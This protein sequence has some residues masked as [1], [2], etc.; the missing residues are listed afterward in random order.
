MPIM[1]NKWP[2]KVFTMDKSLIILDALARKKAFTLSEL[3]IALENTISERTLRRLLKVLAEEGKIKYSGGK[4]NRQYQL[5]ERSSLNTSIPELPSMGREVIFSDKSLEF[6]LKLKAPLYAREPCTYNDIW[7]MGYIPNETFYLSDVQRKLLTECGSQTVHNQPA[8][9]YANKIYDRIL[10]DLSYNS[11]RL[12][13]NTYSLLDTQKLLLE[14]K[15]AEDKIDADRIMILNHKEAIRFL[16][17][18]VERIEVN[19]ECIRTL[20]YLL[21][22]GLVL[23]KHAGNIR[24]DG[25]RISG[26]VYIPLDN[27]SRIEKIFSVIIEKAQKIKDVFEQSF[28]LLAHLSY[29]QAFMDVNKRLARL[30]ANIPLVKNNYIPISFNDIE[31][32]DYQTAVI[33]IYELNE[34]LPLS[35]LFC[36]SYIKTCKEY[37]VTSEAIAFDPQRVRYRQARRTLIA[38]IIKEKVTAKNFRS[39]IEMGADSIPKVDQKK[40]IEDVLE[41]LYHLDIIKLAG[42]GVTRQEFEA[43]Q[44]FNRQ[45]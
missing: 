15:A 24:Q 21:A 18:G 1:A 14:G 41:D 33:A 13:G 32:E 6:F 8:G 42:L 44:A 29:L 45:Q 25:V 39:Y 16:V 38:N 43:W 5:I 7:L 31:K 36:F 20:H 17:K 23:P 26:S 19:E 28:F 27:F 10:I 12:E 2:T 11:S 3:A 34:I 22:D 40:F 4:K 35:D 30:S 37:L 9:T